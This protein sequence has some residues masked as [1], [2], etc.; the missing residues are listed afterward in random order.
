MSEAAT[1]KVR[2]KWEKILVKGVVNVMRDQPD[3]FVRR[4]R[5]GIPEDFRYV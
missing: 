2:S 4:A 1:D 3:V 5:R